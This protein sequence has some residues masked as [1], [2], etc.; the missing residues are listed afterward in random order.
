MRDRLTY[1]GVFL[2]SGLFLYLNASDFLPQ[3]T[4]WREATRRMAMVMFLGVVVMVVTFVLVPCA[5]K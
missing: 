3:I 5:P 1:F 4:E 2:E